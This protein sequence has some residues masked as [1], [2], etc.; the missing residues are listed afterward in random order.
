M[1]VPKEVTRTMAPPPAEPA[2]ES[3][4]WCAIRATRG[5]FATLVIPSV[6][7]AGSGTGT[8][9]IVMTMFPRVGALLAKI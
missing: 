1:V 2:A 6:S 7:L 9:G 5:C 4:E 3:A 8:S